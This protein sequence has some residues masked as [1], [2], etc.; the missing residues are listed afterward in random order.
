MGLLVGFSGYSQKNNY[1]NTMIIPHLNEKIESCNII[2]CSTYRAS[3]TK[4]RNDIIREDVR[5]VK[6]MSIVGN[7][8]NNLYK[9]KNSKE[10]MVFSGFVKDGIIN[11]INS[12]I[13]NNFGN[14]QTSLNNYKK[15]KEGIICFSCYKKEI[16]FPHKFNSLSYE[17]KS[18]EKQ[19]KVDC[20]GIINSNN[21]ELCQQVE[22]FDYKNKDDFV[23]RIKSDNQNEEIVLAKVELCGTLSKTVEQTNARI[24]NNV[25]VLMGKTDKLIVP[26]INF[27]IHHMYNQLK[28]KYLANEGFEEFY[29]LEAIQ[30]I[31]FSMNESGAFASSSV[32]LVLNQKGPQPKELVFNEPF[33]L[34]IKNAQTNEYDLVV[35]INDLELLKRSKNTTSFE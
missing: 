32:E 16:V 7:L 22:V 30:N 23:V 6:P 21:N 19:V 17:F 18:G 1:K 29:F 2:Y 33:L 8:N 3:W 31:Q 5:T 4:L 9:V 12:S 26:K 27:D 24:N 13:K 25:P 14:L 34:M 28:D 15:V 20:F 10:Y 35:W 11:E